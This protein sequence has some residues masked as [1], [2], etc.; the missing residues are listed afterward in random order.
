MTARDYENIISKKNRI[1][2]AEKKMTPL[3]AELLAKVEQ[4][5]K[6]KK[7]NEEDINSAASKKA[8]SVSDSNS[9]TTASESAPVG[10]ISA[11]QNFRQ[12]QAEV[13][14]RLKE[15]KI[16]KDYNK[17]DYNTMAKLN[18]LNSELVAKYGYDGLG[19]KRKN[20]KKK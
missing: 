1:T 5:A 11:Q 20:K 14:N 9:A 3:K 16:E 13:W 8:P 7:A 12:L 4:L 19:L 17:K 18:L 2:K 10:I 15:L 6:N